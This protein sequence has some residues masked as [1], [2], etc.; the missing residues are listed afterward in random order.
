MQEI[1]KFVTGARDLSEID[2]YFN[3]LQKLGAD[4]YVGY[5]ADYYAAQ[6]AAAN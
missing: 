3:E 5:Y 6:Q 4:E 1:A 2:D